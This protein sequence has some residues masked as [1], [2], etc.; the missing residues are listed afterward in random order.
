MERKMM[1]LPAETHAEMMAWLEN[2]ERL[3]GMKITATSFLAQAVKIALGKQV[4]ISI[5]KE[6]RGDTFRTVEWKLVDPK[7]E[8][9]F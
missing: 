6:K 7:E 9:A 2:Q 4:Y 3:T 1:S 5:K 8:P